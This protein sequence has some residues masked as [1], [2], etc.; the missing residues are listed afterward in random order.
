M[1]QMGRLVADQTERALGALSARSAEVASQVIA[2]D[3]TV[4]ALQI[5]IDDRA[6][7]LLALQTPAARDLRL[8]VAAIKANTDLE[9]I[10]DQAVNI[11]ETALRLTG[12]P[13]L[14]HEAVIAEMGRL[15]VSMTRDALA[16]FLDR[17]VALARRVLAQDDD[18]DRLKVEIIRQ[19]IA[20]MT[21]DGT[22]I[23]HALGLVF[24]S[25]N[26]ERVA[27]H[28]TNMAEDAIFMVEARDVRHQHA[29]GPSPVQ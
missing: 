27:D 20:A 21:S 5:E 2:G 16:S 26:L 28:A 22:V 17:D 24:I 3:A 4:N 12:T 11:A 15:A 29:E 13:A 19:L 9:R 14:P 7:K 8:V 1:G 23:D 10:G 25:R 18:A 6:V